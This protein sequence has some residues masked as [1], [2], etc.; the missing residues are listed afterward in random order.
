MTLNSLNHDTVEVSISCTVCGRSYVVRS[1]NEQISDALSHDARVFIACEIVG[2]GET[3]LNLK[4]V[5][6]KPGKCVNS[7]G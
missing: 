5:R 4:I 3:L 2:F 1:W 7:W 6:V